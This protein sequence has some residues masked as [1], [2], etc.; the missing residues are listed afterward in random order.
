M[1]CVETEA[2]RRM[3]EP[4]VKELTGGDRIRARRMREDFWEF[5]PTHHVWLAG[6]H[7]PRVIG[8]DQGIW[9]RIKLIPFEVEISETEQDKKLPAKL[10]AE[11]P[12]ML[13]WALAGCLKWQRDGLQ[14]PEIVLAAT[15][16]YSN[17][18]DDFGEFIEDH[19]EAG[20][21]FEA[22]ATEL[23][24]EFQRVT[25]S[26]MTQRTFGREIGKRGFKSVRISQGINKGRKAWRGLRIRSD[27]TTKTSV[28][29]LKAKMSKKTD[30]RSR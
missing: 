10:A 29:K 14:H 1:A 2:G 21:K 27:A 9:R 23:F 22:P 12:G 8:T 28:N 18:M 7:K 30:G 15:E 25:G 4:L 16:D 17:E 20:L 13:N 19:C 24:R 26:R 6:N 3:D 11:L 5:I